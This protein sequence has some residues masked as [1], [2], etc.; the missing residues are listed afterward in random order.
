MLKHCSYQ[1]INIFYRT[2][3]SGEPVILLHG[4]GEDS[5]VWDTQIDFLKEHCLV[6]VPD[7]PGSGLSDISEAALN[8]KQQSATIE[9]YAECIHALLQQEGIAKCVM[10]GHSMG[11]YI[12]FAFAE[13]YATQLKGWGFVHSTAF[14]DSEEKKANRKRGIEM[15]EEYGS[16]SFLK[17]TTPNLF[18]ALYKQQYPDKVE[19]LVESGKNFKTEALQNYY[20][21][22]MTRPDRTAVLRGSKVPVLFII[23]TEDVAVPLNDALKQT[24][25]PENAFIHILENVGHMGMWEATNDVNDFILSFVKQVK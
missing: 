8:I 7:L 2:E 10:L 22:M 15:M 25:I 14:A 17:N 6:I 9:F 1:Q 23:G 4:F 20:R 16:Y 19:A 12:T 21:A 11:G 24:T 13:K 3:G 18:S 5:H